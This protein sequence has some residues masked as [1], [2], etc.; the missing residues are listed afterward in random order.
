MDVIFLQ[1]AEY[2]LKATKQ[3]KAANDTGELN[4]FS[5]RFISIFY[6]GLKQ[7]AE[8]VHK[9]FSF[10]RERIILYTNGSNDLNPLR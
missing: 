6:Y 10:K 3:A 1:P 2:P 4:R 8:W 5:R 7:M 9:L